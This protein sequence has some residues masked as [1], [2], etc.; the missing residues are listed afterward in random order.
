MTMI[1]LDNIQKSFGSKDSLVN[2]LQGVSL[3]I[4][5][6]ELIAITGTSGSGKSTLLNIIGCLDYPTQGD[7]YL[8]DKPVSHKSKT[9]MA[10]L[11]NEAIGFVMQ[12]FALVDHYTVRQNV[13]LPL[14]Y[15]KD[16]SL[17]KERQQKVDHLLAR[18]GIDN[19]AKEKS[20]LLSGGQK[21]R[22]AIGRALINE[23][24]L[25][26]ADEPT[27]ALDQN[28]SKEILNLL[29][30]LHEEGKTVIIVTHDLEV[31]ALCERII[32]M[33]DGK[34]AGEIKGKPLKERAY[35]TF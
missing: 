10:K 15:V 11:R 5:E 18:L 20:A 26:L 29:L 27:G 2:A 9:E 16:K 3:T 32:Q 8:A 1:R 30:G 6:G 17:R 24:Q 13:A 22:V 4:A 31:A 33:E 34:I 28:T 19:K 7:Y 21:Q 14:M 12:D 25:I 23:P 35:G